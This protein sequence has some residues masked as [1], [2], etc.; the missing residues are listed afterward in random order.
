MAVCLNS[1]DK[2]L[3][4]L[5]TYFVWLL[6]ASEFLVPNS[7]SFWMPRLSFWGAFQKYAGFPATPRLLIKE[8]DCQQ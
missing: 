2:Q 3:L 7:E 6:W 8:G 5:F 4:Q 1:Y